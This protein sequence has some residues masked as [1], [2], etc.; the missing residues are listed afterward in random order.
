[1]E[2]RQDCQSFTLEKELRGKERG[3]KRVND[4]TFDATQLSL[5]SAIN[6]DA[7]WIKI[8]LFL[9]P[10]TTACTLISPEE[11]LRHR[12]L[13]GMQRNVQRH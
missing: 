3:T 10:I 7:V 11:L 9:K 1:M 5:L 4:C 12:R 13:A 6:P 2:N 8:R